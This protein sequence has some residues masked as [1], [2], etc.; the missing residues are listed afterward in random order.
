M[1]AYPH[2]IAEF[3]GYSDAM[4]I[5]IVTRFLEAHSFMMVL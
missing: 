1:K 4:G 3:W 2:R 5:I